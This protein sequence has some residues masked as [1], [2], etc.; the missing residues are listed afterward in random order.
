[1]QTLVHKCMYS[2]QQRI[3]CTWMR[4][5][6]QYTYMLSI[7]IIFCCLCLYHINICTGVTAATHICTYVHTYIRTCAIVLE[8]TDLHM[9]I[10]TYSA[11]TFQT[12]DSTPH[13]DDT[14]DKCYGDGNTSGDCLTHI[15]AL[16]YCCATPIGDIGGIEASAG[17]IR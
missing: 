17:D 5:C 15:P 3:M 8:C 4:K 10:R 1:M 2:K 13:H 7:I 9:Y 11:C 6:V 16:I 14:S 12:H